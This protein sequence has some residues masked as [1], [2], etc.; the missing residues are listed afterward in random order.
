MMSKRGRPRMRKE[1]MSSAEDSPA[2][3]SAEPE[4]ERE[5]EESA[6]D[7]GRSLQ[8]LLPLCVHDLSLWKTCLGCVTT[9]SESSSA[10]YPQSGMTRNGMLYRR[11]HSVRHT[12]GKGC[13][14]W[15]TPTATD[16]K[17]CSPNYK[18]NKRGET[19]TRSYLRAACHPDGVDGST[20]P[21]P[22]FVE[23]LMGFP[24]GWTELN[25]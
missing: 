2:R 23:V 25:H 3:M 19:R 11:V 8:G 17:G 12:H 13:S 4:C 10:I 15:P 14:L 5:L 24:I 9:A 6:A 22:A 1:S 20:Y 16:W 18:K 7:F 21:H